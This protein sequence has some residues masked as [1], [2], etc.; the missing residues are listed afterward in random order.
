MNATEDT[1]C[2]ISTP[3]GVGGIAVARISGP[4]AFAIADLVWK[5]KPLS[6]APTHTAHLGRIVDPENGDTLDEAVATTFRAPR[7][8]TGENVVEL[9]IHGSRWIQRELINLLVRQGCRLAEAGEFTRRAF[10]SGR[11]DLAEAEAVAD[12]I[13]S[14]SKASH[15]IAMS[16][17]RGKFSAELSLLRE[18]L[19]ELASLLELELDFSEEDVE[20]ASRVKLIDIAEEI[21]TKLTRLAN[22]FSTG[23][24]LKNGV[25]V[26]I[27]GAPN[28]GKSTLLN[29]LLGDEKA[30]VSN[31]PGT[32]R[33]VIEDLVEINGVQFRLIDTAGLHDTSD[34][35]ELLGID[36][37]VGQIERARIVLWVIDP[38]TPA[39][40]LQRTLNEISQ[41]RTDDSTL[42]VAKNMLDIV[43]DTNIAIELPSDAVKVEISAATGHG[44]NA[45]ETALINSAGIDNWE[46]EIIVTNA[47]HYEALMHAQNSTERTLQ[48]LRA[49]ISGDFIAQ[50]LRETLHYLG[51]VTGTITTPDILA[52]IFS[53]F[54]IGK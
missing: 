34:T 17:M 42:I 54:C 3:A 8:F 48:G 41:K 44:I 18:R 6:D 16:Q 32:T 45:L 26:A 25:P 38:R 49:N 20:F 9:S 12:V 51:E 43:P 24:A 30:I 52:T 40:Q 29:R 2:A 31:I 27:V 37:T 7:S 21:N 13:A 33:D 53:R 36:R 5:G 4:Q 35:V 28:A 39:D 15:R 23:N 10:A 14:S 22:S 11:L 19:L 46:D 50:D 1:I 47:R